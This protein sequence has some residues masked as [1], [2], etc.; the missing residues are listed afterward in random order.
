MPRKTATIAAYPPNMP[1]PRMMPVSWNAPAPSISYGCTKPAGIA[2]SSTAKSS[3]NAPRVIESRA[4]ASPALRARSPT[5]S[6]RMPVVTDQAMTTT[7]KTSSVR[8]AGTPAIMPAT[9]L[10]SA[11]TTDGQRW[12]AG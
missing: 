10:S 6:S 1:T 12:P 2:I 8:H 7:K 9:K 11:K 4:F 5:T 3:P